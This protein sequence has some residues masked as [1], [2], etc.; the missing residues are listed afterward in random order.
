MGDD[1]WRLL[2]PVREHAGG[3]YELMISAIRRLGRDRKN[4]GGEASDQPR[5][6]LLSLSDY[7]EKQIPLILG[8]ANLFLGD[9][10]PKM[11]EKI[12]ADGS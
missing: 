3:D 8:C 1:L 6:K 9:E 5:G 11:Q 2:A 12:V 4:R 7:T 10:I